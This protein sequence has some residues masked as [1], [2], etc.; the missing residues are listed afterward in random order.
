MPMGH[1]IAFRAE[2][3]IE[4]K[5]LF[6]QLLGIEVSEVSEQR[7]SGTSLRVEGW[8]CAKVLSDSDLARSCRGDSPCCAFGGRRDSGDDPGSVPPGRSSDLG[9]DEELHN[10]Q[11]IRLTFFWGAM[12]RD[13]VPSF[14]QLRS[15]KASLVRMI[16]SSCTQESRASSSKRRDISVRQ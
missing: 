15:N 4:T 16:S 12:V 1:L 11:V 6:T 8:A 10:A 13:A 9:L 3:L 7:L 14:K 2:L 5:S